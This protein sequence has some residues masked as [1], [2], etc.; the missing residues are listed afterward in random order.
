MKLTAK[1]TGLPVYQ[2]TGTDYPL[3]GWRTPTKVVLMSFQTLVP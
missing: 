1:V 2:A 3:V